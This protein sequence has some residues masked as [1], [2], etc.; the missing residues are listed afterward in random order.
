MLTAIFYCV[1]NFCKDLD[2]MQ[3]RFLSEN[4]SNAGRKRSLSEAE[5]MTILIYFHHSRRRT[6]K[7]YYLLNI[8]GYEYRAF[9]HAPSYNRFVELA[10]KLL[11]PL[12]LFINMCRLGAVDRKSV[13]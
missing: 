13:V 6:F 1:D 4:K 7:D 8:K 10:K 3:N 9:P 2:K 12:Y 5:I 11:M